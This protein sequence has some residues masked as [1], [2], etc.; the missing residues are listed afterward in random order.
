MRI[1]RKS[2]KPSRSSRPLYIVGFS[3]AAGA[4]TP[5]ELQ[6][7]FDL[8]YGGPLRLQPAAGNQTQDE[9]SH[10]VAAHGPWS[11]TIDTLA[12][13]EAQTWKAMLEWGHPSAVQVVPM[14]AQTLHRIDQA[15]H[16]ARIARGLTLLSQGTT[17]DVLSVQYLNPSD[18]RDRSLT[19]F[20]A[21]DHV[22]IRQTEAASPD[23][24]WFSTQGMTKF[25]LDELEAFRPRGLSATP[26]T[27]TL[28]DIAEALIR[29]G[30]IPKVGTV[31]SL[32]ELGLSVEILRHRTAVI[33]GATVPLREINWKPLS[34]R[35]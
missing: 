20:A 4:P 5:S 1:R 26:V 33:G 3:G 12:A 14:A 21:R 16:A 2:P 10:L 17:Y 22:S 8:E 23:Q 15:L 32:P 7:W 13:D 27:E 31:L 29:Q 30:Q 6:Y 24:E 11:V 9:P 25:G 19:Q 28:T 34:L 18:W 35:P